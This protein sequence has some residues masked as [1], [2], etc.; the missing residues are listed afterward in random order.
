MAS[1]P[2]SSLPSFEEAVLYLR[3]NGFGRSLQKL[4][5]AYVVGRQT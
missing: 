1:N 4:L 2:L 5:A 3:N